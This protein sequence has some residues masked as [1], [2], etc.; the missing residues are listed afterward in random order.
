MR[1]SSALLLTLAVAPALHGCRLPSSGEANERRGGDP[2]LTVAFDGTASA[3][4]PLPSGEATAGALDRTWSTLFQNAGVEMQVYPAGVIAGLHTQYLLDERRALTFRIAANVADRNDYGKQDDEQGGGWGVGAGY[5]S[6]F[7]PRR[8]GWLWGARADLW[9]LE[10]DWTDDPGLPGEQS[11]STDVLVFQ[12]TIE[13]G[14]GW[15]LG[16]WRLELLAG[17]GFE[18]NVVEHGRDVGEGPIGLLGVTLVSDFG[19]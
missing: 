15:D 10:I 9:T 7:G 19:E 2:A 8:E 1:T 16:D 4:G 14:Y 6:Y 3:R 13:A 5:R 17:F 11:G 12:P 18:I